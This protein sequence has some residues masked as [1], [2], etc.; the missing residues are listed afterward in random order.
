[1]T[2]SISFKL[3]LSGVLSQVSE[4]DDVM[5]GMESFYNKRSCWKNYSENDSVKVFI[6]VWNLSE[7][8]QEGAMQLKEDIKHMSK[9]S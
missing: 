8:F 9:G 3:S 6:S 4:E 2:E 1:M 7:R 5:F